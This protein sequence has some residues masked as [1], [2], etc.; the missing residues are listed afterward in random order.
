M[1]YWE[2]SKSYRFEASHQLPHHDGKC[3]SLHGHSWVLTITIKASKLNDSGPQ[4][5]MVM[6]YG[7][8][9]LIVN[10]LIDELD[11]NHLN[12]ILENPTSENL[13]EY[14]FNN[15]YLKF[16][17]K[18]IILVCVEINETCSS[19]VKYYGN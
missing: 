15:L 7:R 2:L 6:D 8:M 11:H 16:L 17:E 14:I 13:A 3:N 1:P 4:N 12:L 5:G 19:G 10:H 9:N 18:K